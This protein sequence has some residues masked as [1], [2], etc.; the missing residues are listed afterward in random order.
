MSTVTTKPPKSISA[1]LSQLPPFPPV[2]A[3]LIALVTAPRVAFGQVAEL[4]RS[5]AAFAARTLRLANSPLLG[6]REVTSLLQAISMLGSD[7][8]NALVMTLGVHHMVSREARCEVQR[9][10]WRHCLATACAAEFLAPRFN[11]KSDI[12]Y[13]G[14]LL[15]DVGCLALARTSEYEALLRSVSCIEEQLE[16]ETARYGMDHGRLGAL[17]VQHWGLPRQLQP[18]MSEHHS[19]NENSDPQVYLIRLADCIADRVGFTMLHPPNQVEFPEWLESEMENG[20]LTDF[21]LARV[22]DLERSLV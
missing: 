15:H 3:K 11:L 7:R 16:A 1:L 8:L 10:C 2:A 6:G 9:Y 4:V 5:D 13:T 21:I 19:A 18:L 20:V 14:G 12:A 17:L 22:N